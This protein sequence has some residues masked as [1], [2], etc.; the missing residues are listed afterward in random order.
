L[1]AERARGRA[2]QVA[3]SVMTLGYG[4]FLVGP[5]LIGL[6]AELAGLRSALLLIPA[7]GALI[8]LAGTRSPRRASAA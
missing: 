6:V 4:G 7:A 8:A 2:G 1:A 5:P 3:A